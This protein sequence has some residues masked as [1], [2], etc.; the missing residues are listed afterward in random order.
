MA[1]LGETFPAPKVKYREVLEVSNPVDG[2]PQNMM[3]EQYISIMKPTDALGVAQK[4]FY[5]L[6]IQYFE[7]ELLEKL[8]MST[9]MS[10]MGRIPL[11]KN[12]TIDRLSLGNIVFSDH[13]KRNKLNKITHPHIMKELMKSIDEVKIRSEKLVREE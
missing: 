9:R 10:M 13:N 11:V 1:V 6:Y 5:E 7:K 2:L 3:S 4:E 12:N 8:S